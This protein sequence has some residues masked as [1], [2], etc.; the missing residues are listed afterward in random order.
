MQQ[1]RSTAAAVAAVPL[2]L[3]LV[4][5]HAA[6]AL[7]FARGPGPIVGLGQEIRGIPVCPVGLPA[8][9]MHGCYTPLLTKCDTHNGCISVK[10]L[11]QLSALVRFGGSPAE[12]A[13]RCPIGFAN[14]CG[15]QFCDMGEVC[16]GG[17]SCQSSSATPLPPAAKAGTS[18]AA[19]KAACIAA[20]RT[21]SVCSSDTSDLEV[22]DCNGIGVASIE[23]VTCFQSQLFNCA[24][25]RGGS[26]TYTC[27][28]IAGVAQVVTEVW[29]STINTAAAMAQEMADAIAKQEQEQAA[30]QEASGGDGVP[31]VLSD[32]LGSGSSRG[33]GIEGTAQELWRAGKEVALDKLNHAVHDK[34]QPLLQPIF[35]NLAH[36]VN[37]ASKS[38]LNIT[39]E[40]GSVAAD[41]SGKI[42]GILPRPPTFDLGP[43]PIRDAAG[44]LGPQHPLLLLLVSWPP[45]VCVCVVCG[46]RQWSG[47]GTEAATQ[48]EPHCCLCC[49]LWCCV[50]P[51]VF[52]GGCSVRGV[53]VDAAIVQRHNCS[54][55][56]SMA[57]EH[58]LPSQ[59][60][61][62]SLGG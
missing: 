29:N 36:M 17:N 11:S 59:Q 56:S 3:L 43:P 26:A 9:G 23:G 54:S 35:Q 39:A 40:M 12:S 10:I 27:R 58:V 19:K 37:N 47:L 44:E 4:F 46:V 21:A 33:G 8:C 55:S 6:S 61:C 18:A 25:Q 24:V 32:T 16:V 60:W 38:L 48:P 30:A 53:S 42:L 28:G 7:R 2:A 1:R 62:T 31:V 41:G 13:G 51:L 20:R 14:A 49:C 22:V 50:I 45:T 52:A 34:G 15:S 5:S 57:D